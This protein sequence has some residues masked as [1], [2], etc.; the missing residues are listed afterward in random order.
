MRLLSLKIKGPSQNFVKVQICY[1][2]NLEQLMEIGRWPL[3]LG[4]WRDAEINAVVI[5]T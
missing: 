2:M 3:F 5:I 1:K 4:L